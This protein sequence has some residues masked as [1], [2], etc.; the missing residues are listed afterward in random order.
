MDAIDRM[1]ADVMRVSRQVCSMFAME[2]HAVAVDLVTMAN[3]LAGGLPLS[4]VCSRSDIM[5]A[6]APGGLGGTYGGNPLAIAAAHAVLDEALGVLEQ[7][8]TR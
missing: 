3:S 1:A 2:H 4:A 7:A 5:D 8:L 6:P